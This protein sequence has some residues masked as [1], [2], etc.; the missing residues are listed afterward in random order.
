MEDFIRLN[1]GDKYA[2]F[3]K[4]TTADERT[5]IDLNFISI[6]AT[7]QSKQPVSVEKETIIKDG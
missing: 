5:Q 3:Y 4:E 7:G 6:L 2:N 1:L